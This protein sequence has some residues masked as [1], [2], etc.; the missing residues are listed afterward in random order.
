MGRFKKGLFFGGLLGATL[1]WM[2]T[3]KK[4]RQTRDQMLDHAAEVYRLVKD[5]VQESQA[6]DSMTKQA[7]VAKVRDVVDKYAIDNGLADNVK[8]MIMKVV[9][10]QWASVK[11]EVG[12]QKKK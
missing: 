10:R 5:K 12:K 6:W 8:N 11:Q 9:S 2:S 1:T 4:G 3:T 7:Y